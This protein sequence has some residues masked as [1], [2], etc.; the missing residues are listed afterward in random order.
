VVHI[1]NNQSSADRAGNGL[2]SILFDKTVFIPYLPKE[3]YLDPNLLDRYTGKYQTSS[4]IE[5]RREGN[6]LFRHAENGPPIE[7]KAESLNRL[8]YTDRSGRFLEFEF[9]P[10]G[11]VSRAWFIQNGEKTEM[12]KV[13]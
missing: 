5:I 3:T 8:F 12:K 7:L 1:T 9:D 6:V 10:Q 11:R 4:L 2:A 13:E